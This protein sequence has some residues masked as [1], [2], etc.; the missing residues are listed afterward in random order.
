MEL[1]FRKYIA[2]QCSPAEI[3]QLLDYFALEGPH[4]LLL[5]EMI[6]QHLENQLPMPVADEEDRLQDV[7]LLR[8]VPLYKRV[9]FRAAASLVFLLALAAYFF[10]P[11]KHSEKKKEAATIAENTRD[12]EPGSNKA[13]LTLGDGTVITLDSL[14]SGMVALQGTSRVV[15]LGDGKLAYE[16]LENTIAQEPVFNTIATPRGGEYDLVLA[17]GTGVWL[18]AA[19]S[20]KFPAAFTG[21]ERRVIIT[22]EV[23]FEVAKNAKMPFKVIVNND[24]E[25]EVLGTHFNIKAYAEEAG[26][27]TSLLE[28]KVKLTSLKDAGKQRLLVAGEQATY[29]GGNIQVTRN[30][31]QEVVMSWKRGLFHFNK[32]SIEDIMR[33]V[34]R[35]YDVDVKYQG[36]KS[37]ATFSGIVNRGSKVSQVL[38]VM[39]QA[40][41]R[42]RVE[43]DLITVM[44]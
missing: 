41:I 39:E 24:V 25:V 35:W 36:R 42:F 21:N 17:D 19:S 13:T 26:I 37:D 28:G 8:T 44:E 14:Q 6:L 20:L 34:S 40:G 38:R 22:G 10:W 4:E 27:Q 30:F 11:P 33:Q 23:Y 7:Q 16:G 2:N 12:I 3:D 15:K 29:T 32:T 43:K 31:D 5:K 9:A 18:N 1:L